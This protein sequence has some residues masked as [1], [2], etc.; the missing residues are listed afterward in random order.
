M[1]RSYKKTPINKDKNKSVQKN[2]NRKVRQQNKVH[3]KYFDEPNEV[4][5]SH[6]YIKNG[7]AYRFVVCPYDISDWSNYYP[8][9]EYVRDNENRKDAVHMRSICKPDHDWEKFFKRK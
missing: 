8:E 2:A 5:R 6:D 4:V 3:Q 1:S 9:S 7:K